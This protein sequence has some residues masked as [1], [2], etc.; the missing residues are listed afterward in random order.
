MTT[1]LLREIDPMQTVGNIAVNIPGATAVFRRFKLDFCCGGNKSLAFAA[2]EKSLNVEHIVEELEALAPQ[3]IDG[4]QTLQTD[5]LIHH[6]VSRYH[7]THRA[8][9]PELIRMAARVET[10]HRDK[11]EVP[12]GL[13]AHL[14]RMSEEMQLHMQKEEFMLFP[15]MKRGGHSMLSG[16]IGCMRN[17]HE[18]H[19]NNLERLAQLTNDFT[20]PQGACN[21]WRALFNGLAALRDDLIEHV[22]LENNVLFPRFEERAVMPACECGD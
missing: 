6:I 17:E 18:D 9:F 14:E 15:M 22:H 20:P 19:G 12:I 4:P 13:T 11:P 16:P 10:V 2:K 7:E 21:T 5:A 1:V 3:T 8:Q